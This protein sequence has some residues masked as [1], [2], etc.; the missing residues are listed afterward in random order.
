MC[1]QNVPFGVAPWKK[2]WHGVEQI[3]FVLFFWLRALIKNGVPGSLR[4]SSGTLVPMPLFWNY[5]GARAQQKLITGN[6][7]G[8]ALENCAPKVV[9]A[10][11][12]CSV[13][14]L[15]EKVKNSRGVQ[16]CTFSLSTLRHLI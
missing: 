1:A 3:E 16:K 8:G 14:E 7:S 9:P 10:R 12:K 2:K 13:R 5:F 6:N 11:A 4:F 15:F